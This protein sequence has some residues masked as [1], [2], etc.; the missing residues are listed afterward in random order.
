MSTV[1][2]KVLAHQK[3]LDGTWNVKISVCQKSIT[4]YIDTV[5]FVSQNQLTRGWK[6]RIP[7]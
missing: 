6:S 4:K 3:K 2:A 1:N 5:H 7:S